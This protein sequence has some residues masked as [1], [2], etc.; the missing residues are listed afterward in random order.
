MQTIKKRFVKGEEKCYGVLV[1]DMMQ[2]IFLDDDGI[3]KV[4]ICADNEKIRLV[5][6]K[7]KCCDV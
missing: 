7:E 6:G 4:T 3:T 1:S 2:K 5:K